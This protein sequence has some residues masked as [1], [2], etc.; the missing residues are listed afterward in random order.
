MAKIAAGQLPG[1]EMSIAKLS[2]TA[3]H[4]S[5]VRSGCSSVLGPQLVADTGEWGTYAWS[6]F[7]LGVPGMRIAGGTDEVLHNIIGERV[8]G[9]PKEPA[10]SGR[11]PRAPVDRR[12]HAVSR[13][14]AGS[15]RR[16]TT[17][18]ARE[19]SPIP[20]QRGA[21][22]RD[23]Y[24][25]FRSKSKAGKLGPTSRASSGHGSPWPRSRRR[26]WRLAG[27]VAPDHGPHLGPAAGASI[28]ATGSVR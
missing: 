17:V 27:G 18:G 3:E 11:E 28:T 25:L 19:V 9:L 13:P 2:L 24:P 14:R 1:P 16:P 15:R 4:A 20:T 23:G 10:P 6:Q 22:R 5:R 21:V 12:A 8:L 7:L 26:R